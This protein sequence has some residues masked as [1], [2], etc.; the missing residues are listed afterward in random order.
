VSAN[1]NGKALAQVI[2]IPTAISVVTLAL[3]LWALRK[4]LG[5]R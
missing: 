5:A 3:A 2:L 1:L 4:R